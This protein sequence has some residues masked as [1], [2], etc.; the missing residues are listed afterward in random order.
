MSATPMVRWDGEVYC[1]SRIYLRIAICASP[2]IGGEEFM[3]RN[4]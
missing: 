4:L 3:N 2:L 1:A